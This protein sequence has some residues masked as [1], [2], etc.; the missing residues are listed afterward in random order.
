MKYINTFKIF[1]NDNNNN[2]EDFAFYFED[3][4]GKTLKLGS[5]FLNEDKEMFIYWK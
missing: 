5:E 2:L 3:V 1:E 4:F